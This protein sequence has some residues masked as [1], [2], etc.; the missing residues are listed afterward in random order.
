MSAGVMFSKINSNS[1]LS[2][3]TGTDFLI[4]RDLYLLLVIACVLHGHFAA[5]S[6]LLLL[7]SGTRKGERQILISK[8]GWS[9]L[10]NPSLSFPASFITGLD[11]YLEIDLS[12]P[13]Y[14]TV[15]AQRFKRRRKKI[16]RKGNDEYYHLAESIQPA[17]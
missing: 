17:H 12:A 8:C 16:L 9:L 15:H 4:S 7:I 5:L 2:R 10:Y 6:L 3:D 1:S 13:V 14:H 11:I